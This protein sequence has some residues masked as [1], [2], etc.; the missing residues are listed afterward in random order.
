MLV[1]DLP[2][3]PWNHIYDGRAKTWI[4]GLK[5]VADSAGP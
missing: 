3:I 4:E 2:R 5:S 1:Y